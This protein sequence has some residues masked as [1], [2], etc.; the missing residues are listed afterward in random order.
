MTQLLS[1][2]SAIFWGALVLNVLVFVH[3]GGHYLA[4][5]A[6]GMRVTEFFV[7]MPC[8]FRLSRRSRS[9]G[10]EFGVTPILVGGYTRICGMEGELG[11][12]AADVLA[13][14]ARRGHATVAQVAA[15]AGCSERE[16]LDELAM[17]VDWASV[18][19]R[20]PEGTRPSRTEWPEEFQTVRRDKDLLTAFDAHHDFSAGGST[21]AGEPHEVP[22]G[23]AEALLARERSRTYLGKGFLPRFAALLA[24]PA[25][26]IVLG[27]VLVA[28]TLSV[29]GVTAARDVPVIGEVSEGSLAAVS[30][31]RA[32]D[33]IETVDGVAVSTWVGMGEELRQAIGEGRPFECSIVRDGSS[34]TVTVDP[35]LASDGSGLFGVVAS[36][37]TYHP[38]PLQSLSWACNY[39]GMTANYVLQLLQPA[40]AQQIVSQSSSVVG[41][42]VAASQAASRGPVDL[43]FLM[44]AISLSL[45]FMNLLPIPP[46]DGGKIAIEVIQAIVRRPVP[47][48]AQTV[49]SYLGLAAMLLLFFFVLQQDIVRIVTGG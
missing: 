48:R 17:L 6:F 28:G 44:A 11:P 36:T 46:L 33:E 15:D 14:V 16:A 43:L 22:D 38:G 13:S 32:G 8:R 34:L 30:G 7:G 35:A 25:V 2:L 45:G 49:V 20:W 41:I 3:E 18:E 47:I 40:H 27:L 21:E 19:P 42:S 10:T 24:G 4:A 23:D 37:E 29:G 1:V 9:R 39:V 5:R 12:H 31:I 26:N